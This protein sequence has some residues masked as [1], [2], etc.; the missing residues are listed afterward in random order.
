MITAVT[1]TKHRPDPRGAAHAL[2]RVVVCVCVCASPL[3]IIIIVIIV[4]DIINVMYS[5]IID[6]IVLDIIILDYVPLILI[7]L[8]TQAL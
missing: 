3:N 6:I 5:I 4:D 7:L 8:L 1:I 2:D